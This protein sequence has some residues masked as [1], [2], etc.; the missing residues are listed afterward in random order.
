MLKPIL[1]CPHNHNKGNNMSR[2]G[3]LSHVVWHC[4]YHIVWTPKYRYKILKSAIAR[5]IYNCVNVYSSRLGCG[6]VE[7]NVQLDQCIC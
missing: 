1:S 2:F 7:L 3:K 5:E 6:V 4:Q